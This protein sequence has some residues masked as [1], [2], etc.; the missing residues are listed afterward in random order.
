MAS[1][2]YANCKS[3]TRFLEIFKQLSDG[4]YDRLTPGLSY[5]PSY[6]PP[7]KAVNFVIVANAIIYVLHQ[8]SAQ[9]QNTNNTKVDKSILCIAIKVVTGNKSGTRTFSEEKH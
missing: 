1:V 2:N 5:V 8:M 9:Y 7:E 6:V 4:T 3:D